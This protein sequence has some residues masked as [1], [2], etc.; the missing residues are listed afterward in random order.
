M[1]AAAQAFVRREVL[2]YLVVARIVPILIYL[3]AR[4]NLHLASLAGQTLYAVLIYVYHVL[5]RVC[6]YVSSCNC[7]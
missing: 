4:E 6:V 3:A 5:H 1:L 2:G 7:R